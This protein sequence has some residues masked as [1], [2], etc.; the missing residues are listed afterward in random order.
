[1][2]TMVVW[3]FED[4]ENGGVWVP[5]E[6]KNQ[7]IIER[8]WL[9]HQHQH[10]HRYHHLDNDHNDYSNGGGTAFG[11]PYRQDTTLPQDECNSSNEEQKEL[12]VDVMDLHFSGGSVTVFPG[13]G[14]ASA[15]NGDLLVVRVNSG[16]IEPA[17]TESAGVTIV[18]QGPAAG[19][20]GWSGRPRSNSVHPRP[21]S[22]GRRRANS[23][24]S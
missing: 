19:G 10:Q 13:H 17:V 3:L 2:P 1:M 23:A 12:A 14:L 4:F 8:A 6:L 20:C 15:P 5:F 22:G 18:G 9:Q 11:G 24:Q 16:K 21:V 7:A